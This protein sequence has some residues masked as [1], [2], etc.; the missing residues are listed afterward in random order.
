MA[1]I[2]AL[3]ASLLAPTPSNITSEAD[4]RAVRAYPSE[5]TVVLAQHLFALL[6]QCA[7]KNTSNEEYNKYLRAT[8]DQIHRTADYIFRAVFEDHVSSARVN[9]VSATIKDYSDIVSDEVNDILEL[10]GWR[11][12]EAGCERLIGLLRLLQSTIGV[13]SSSALTIPVGFIVL[14]IE[15]VFSVIVPPKP[16]QQKSGL[17]ARWNPEV[18]RDER[19]G[20]WLKLPQIHVAVIAVVSTLIDRLDV[21]SIAILQGLLEQVLWVFRHENDCWDLRKVVYGVMSQILGTIGPSLSQGTV[22]SLSFLFRTLCSD[23]LDEEARSE[24]SSNL[25]ADRGKISSL[26][27]SNADSYLKPYNISTKNLEVNS[28]LHEAAA[29]LLS[30]IFSHIDTSFLSVPIRTLIDRT[31]ILTNNREA[32]FASVLNPESRAKGKQTSSILPFFARASGTTLELEGTL[33]PRMPILQQAKFD[34][35][36]IDAEEEEDIDMIA[37]YAD[38][39]VTQ[40]ESIAPTNNVGEEQI[41]TFTNDTLEVARK[42]Q[43]ASLNQMEST[44]TAVQHH[45]TID[46]TKRSREADSSVDMGQSSKSR[47]VLPLNKRTRVE[48]ENIEEKPPSQGYS[49]PFAPIYNKRPEKSDSGATE[50]TIGPEVSAS[51]N[52][53]IDLATDSDDSFEIPPI[54]LDSDSDDD[55]EESEDDDR[56]EDGEPRQD[57]EKENI[58]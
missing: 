1:Q 7:P 46:S 42:A 32:M 43:D 21:A 5:M 10:S 50:S 27:M 45:L 56:M 49:T 14:T 57:K 3:L 18:D 41:P 29:A 11:G 2:R 51:G 19:E 30:S 53:A 36:A 39:S 54:I 47:S 16:D 4:L 40:R 25:T 44:S 58:V 52:H 24:A 35:R 33:R 28:E 23:L 12:I 55:E 17:Q 9:A 15:R 8:L 34:H 6:P 38:H 20:M 48:E 22:S 26:K 31:A 37:A 13:E